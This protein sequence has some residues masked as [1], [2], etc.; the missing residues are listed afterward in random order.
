MTKPQA[1]QV[2]IRSARL[3]L[4]FTVPQPEHVL[5]EGNHRSATASCPLFHPVLSSSWRLIS[6]KEAS[7]MCRASLWFSEHARD[8]EVLHE[9]GAVGGGHVGGE[10][11]DRVFAQIRDPS[12]D[13]GHFS[14][15]GFPAGRGSVPGTP[16]GAHAPRTP[17]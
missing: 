12:V 11:V 5:L 3:S 8:G 7:A 9:D 17:P 4:G 13:T 10:L 16:G 6:P 1:S 15:G 14:P 2:K